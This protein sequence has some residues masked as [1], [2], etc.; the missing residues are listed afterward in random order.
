MEDNDVNKYV[1]IEVK[2]GEK[3]GYPIFYFIVKYPKE[4]LSGCSVELE[5]VDNWG[6]TKTHHLSLQELLQY[7]SEESCLNFNWQDSYY[8]NNHNLEVKIKSVTLEKSGK[9]ILAQ[10]IDNIPESVK[11]YLEDP[12]EYN[13][14]PLIKET[15]DEGFPSKIEY[16]NNAIITKLKEKN[17]VIYNL[18]ERIEETA[19]YPIVHRGFDSN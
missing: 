1:D 4:K 6:Y 14:Y 15:I 2:T 13:E 16:V 19:G 17:S 7:N 9:T 5:F 18:I 3:M 10:D 8:W 12:S 11:H